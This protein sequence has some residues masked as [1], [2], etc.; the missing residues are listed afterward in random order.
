MITAEE[1]AFRARVRAALEVWRAR[2]RYEAPYAYVTYHNQCNGTLWTTRYGGRAIM[3][4]ADLLE[5]YE[6]RL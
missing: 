4:L 6:V 2:H 1:R 3:S 5:Q